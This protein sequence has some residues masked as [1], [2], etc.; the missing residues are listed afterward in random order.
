MA[1]D[2][3]EVSRDR[4]LRRELRR[5]PVA[6]LLLRLDQRARL[7]KDGECWVYLGSHDEDGYPRIWWQGRNWHVTRALM[8]A[9]GGEDL[10][11]W[12]QVH[13]TCLNEWCVNPAHM[14]VMHW[15]EHHWVHG[16]RRRTEDDVAAD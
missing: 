8:T 6:N 7:H 2:G 4:A 3:G 12:E 9:L 10:A 5:C 16:W 1:D 15:R 13:H 14:R 11:R